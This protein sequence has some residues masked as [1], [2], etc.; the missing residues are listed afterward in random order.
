[1]HPKILLVIMSN[2]LSWNKHSGSIITK[3]SKRVYAVYQLK[4][5]GVSQNIC[6]ES[7]YPLF[8]RW[9]NMSAQFGTLTW[10]GISR[11][12][13]KWFKSG[14]LGQYTPVCH[15]LRP[16]RS[17]TC[18]L[19]STGEKNCV[20]KYFTSLKCKDH[21]LHHLLP[22]SRDVS[23]PPRDGAPLLL[24]KFNSIV[25]WSIRNDTKP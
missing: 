20:K 18:K 15:I 24:P 25:P 8:A 6:W 23:F 19:Y 7:I 10:R 12:L 14:P 16:C 11:T 17:P 9:L 13:S 4:R 22:P 1:M 21:K 3:V 2:D 5:A